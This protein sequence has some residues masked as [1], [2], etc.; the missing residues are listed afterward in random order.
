MRRIILLLTIAFIT[1]AVMAS[2][3]EAQVDLLN[4]EAITTQTEDVEF[5]LE[6]TADRLGVEEG[7]VT[8]EAFAT[9]GDVSIE[10]FAAGIADEVN[11]EAIEDD[12]DIID[13][14]EVPDIIVD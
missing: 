14:E 13:E 5:W 4:P 11:L 7:E 2:T 1:V 12:E 6:I 9:V 8:P 3:A 10:V